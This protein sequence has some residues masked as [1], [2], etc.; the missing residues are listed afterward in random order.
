VTIRFAV[1]KHL[2][3][4]VRTLVREISAGGSEVKVLGER[5]DY[6]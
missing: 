6:R 3:D 5:F 2:T 1:K 4:D